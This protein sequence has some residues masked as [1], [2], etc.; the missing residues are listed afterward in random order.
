VAIGH[1]VFLSYASQDAEAAQRIC[2]ALRAA[3]IEAFFL[4]QSELRGGDAWDQM[5][6]QRIRDCALFIPVISAN[7][8][9]RH[10]GYFRLEW[11]LADRRTHMIARD[12][13][14]IVPVCIDRTPDSGTDVPE[15][16][17]R[18]QWS[19][20]PGGETP[21]A[22]VA[23]ISHLLSPHQANRPAQALSSTP[24]ASAPPTP[25]PSPAASRPSQT[26]LLLIVVLAVVGV[27]YLAMDKWAPVK[28]SVISIPSESAPSAIP[29][30]SVAVLPF[31]NMSSDK[32]QEYF[33]DG[34]T[35]ELIDLLSQVHDLRVPARTSSFYFKGKQAT[36]AEI[37]KSLG[38][39]HV[40]EGSVRKAGDTLRVTVQLIRA[41]NGYHLWS[42][43]YDADTKDIFKV[44]D[45]VATAVVEVLKTKLVPTQSIASSR[46]ANPEAYNQY[47]LGR[48]FGKRGNI[49][50]WQRSL[51]AF[52]KAIALDPNYAAAYA[53][54]AV[55][56]IFVADLRGDTEGLKR[57]EA[58]AEKA[59]ALAPDDADGCRLREAIAAA[60]KAIELNPLS[61]AEWNNLGADL[62]NNRDYSAAGEALRRSLEIQ[63]DF[64]YALDNLGRLQLL[65]NKAADALVTF[66]TVVGLHGSKRSGVAMAEHTLGHVKNSQQALDELIAK[67]AQNAAY[68]IAEVFA[69][70]GE[71]NKAFEWLDRAYQ[72]RESN[73]SSV[74]VDPLFASLR[75]DPRYKALLRKMNLPE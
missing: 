64:P 2:E 27:G 51:K 36:I 50:D 65:E 31:L 49:D 74:K 12:R 39:A 46:T 23:R 17:V 61:S 33:S 60:R 38:V 4:D 54:L 40:L 22:F 14:F 20:L 16:F 13:A 8:S 67:E 24:P 21:P 47:L 29:E 59:I 53:G 69:W 43:R 3:G 5:I 75:V 7:T 62:M 19:R 6:R 41:E 73:L 28:H 30:K 55:A 48:Q 70:R 37:A 9:S 11:D 71:S 26:L 32:E 15:S 57:A 52:S 72:R 1:A 56:E 66:R 63:P 45:A 68:E 58:A 44:Q 10:E 25:A 42:N 18:V 34:L 35:D